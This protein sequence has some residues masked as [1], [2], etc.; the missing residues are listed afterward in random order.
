MKNFYWRS[1]H[2]NFGDDINAFL[3]EELIP[4]AFTEDDGTIFVGIGTILS[5]EIPRAKRRV[6]M[7]SGTGYGRLPSDL[8]D[9]SWRIFSVRGPLTAKAIGHPPE[10]AVAD[11]A[12]LLARLPEFEKYERHDKAVF[13]PHWKTAVNGLWKEACLRASIELIDPRDEAKS[14]I[15]RIAMAKLMLAES[16]HAAIV[17]DAFR[18]PWIPVISTQDTPFKWHD[19]ALSMELQYDP[20]PIAHLSSPY[21]YLKSIWKNRHSKD[22]KDYYKTVEEQY[23]AFLN[24]SAGAGVP[25]SPSKFRQNLKQMLERGLRS[26]MSDEAMIERGAKSLSRTCSLSPLLSRDQV[27]KTRQD[28]LLDRIETLKRT[29]M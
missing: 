18:V 2:G 16:M 25:P 24:R 9:G 7:G 3:W 12:I 28:T 14:V 13:V 5:H 20:V 17:A 22:R 27:L 11:P 4:G 26:I 10:A 23:L 19:W 8:D 29:I 15:R 6:V 21:T 1:V